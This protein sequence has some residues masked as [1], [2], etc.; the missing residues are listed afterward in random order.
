MM[1]SAGG[2]YAGSVIV[3]TY[4]ILYVFVYIY[5]YIIGGNRKA[6]AMK[7]GTRKQRESAKL[8]L[9]LLVLFFLDLFFSK[10]IFF[11]LLFKVVNS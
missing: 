7:G 2:V 1:I 9:S 5:I 4:C 11:G 6:F 10:K 3:Y 8:S